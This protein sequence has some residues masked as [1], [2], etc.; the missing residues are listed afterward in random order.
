MQ[1]SAGILFIYNG[2]ILLG[3]P[4]NN[5][6]YHTYSIPKGGVDENEDIKTAAI[7]ETFEEIGISVKPAML[8]SVHS[9][10]YKSKGKYTDVPKGEIYKTLY[11]YV[12]QISD[13]AEIG[14]T[15]EVVPKNQLQLAEIDWAGF[16]DYHEAKKRIAPVMLDCLKHIKKNENMSIKLKSF[17][18]GF[19]SEQKPSE[20]RYVK[21]F[22][23]FVQE[24]EAGEKAQAEEA[25]KVEEK[26]FYQSKGQKNENKKPEVNEARDWYD[27]DIDD[28]IHDFKKDNTN[29][30]IDM[31][32]INQWFDMFAQDKRI[33]DSI[34]EDVADDLEDALKKA[35][36]KKA[37]SE[38]L[39]NPY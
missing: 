11:Y 27:F 35:G 10:P 14:L 1:K 19:M 25:T 29:K 22:E 6:W 23:E 33:E 36:Y 37:N 24:T 12:V 39:Q 9:I 2:K 21:T 7:R 32:D 31:S 13:L 18:E 34:P 16:I 20:K 28:I 3:H 26:G 15:S 17:N 4:T 8:K 30:N 38:K 5:K